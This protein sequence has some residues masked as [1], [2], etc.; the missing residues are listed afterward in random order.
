MGSVDSGA[1]LGNPNS[2]VKLAA[3]LL[4]QDVGPCR[5]PFYTRD[6]SVKEKVAEVLRTYYAG[7]E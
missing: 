5:S 4:G 6:E 1:A 2:I 3:N 7:A